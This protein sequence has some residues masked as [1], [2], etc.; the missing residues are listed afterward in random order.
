MEKEY[1]S[2]EESAKLIK[3][4]KSQFLYA[5]DILHN[6][7]LSSIPYPCTMILQVTVQWCLQ[8]QANISNQQKQKVMHK[9]SVV[10]NIAA[11]KCFLLSL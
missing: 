2:I 6:P 8:T 10:Y 7:I 3:S 1:L 5:T 11:Y 4:F 9:S